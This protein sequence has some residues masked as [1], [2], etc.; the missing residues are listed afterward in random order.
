MARVHV[1]RVASIEGACWR[2]HSMKTMQFR[3]MSIGTRLTMVVLC[4]FAVLMAFGISAGI[5]RSY[6]TWKYA[7]YLAY[8][9]SPV[10]ATICLL[11][12]SDAADDLLCV[13]LGG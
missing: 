10:L 7:A 1:C 12:T 9:G 8:F 11:Y 5:I 3:K 13:D 2:A 4:W 6:T